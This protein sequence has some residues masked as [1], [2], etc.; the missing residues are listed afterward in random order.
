MHHEPSRDDLDL[1][2]LEE[3]RHRLDHKWALRVIAALIEGPLRFN[4]LRQ[5]VSEL[6]DGKPISVS[7]LSETLHD[8]ADYGL[9]SNTRD[10]SSKPIIVSIYALTEN[11]R[12]NLPELQEVAR[13]FLAEPGDQSGRP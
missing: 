3:F 10:E 1:E 12:K 5:A 9:V 13:R 8:L 6:A 7:V 4:E 11:A 2:V